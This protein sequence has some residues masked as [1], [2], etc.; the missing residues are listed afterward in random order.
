MFYCVVRFCI[1]RH[2]CNFVGIKFLQISLSFL[3]MIIYKVL[4]IGIIFAVPGY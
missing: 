2:G 3:S 4:G 1:V